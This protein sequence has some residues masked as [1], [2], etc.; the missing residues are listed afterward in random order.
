VADSAT[1][2]AGV[3]RE[4][5][6][7]VHDLS[8]AAAVLEWDLETQMPPQGI[9]GRSKLLSTI[10]GLRH[11]R[12]TSSA[13]ADAL[14]AAAEA[15]APDS[16]DAAQ[17]REV[18]RVVER[19]A[20]VPTA[21]AKRLAEASSRGHVAWKRAREEGSF[22]VFEDSLEEL[23]QLRKEEA[24][25]IGAGERLPFD[26]LLDE[27][28][29][30]AT[31]AQL[32]PL[33]DELRSSLG[34]I[35]RAV[36]DSGVVVDES[37]VT[38]TFRPDAQ[39]RF[40]KG[41]AEAMGFDFEAGRLDR[42]PHPF[43]SGFGSGDVRITWRWL[44]DDVRSALFGIMHE[45]G[46]GLYE[47]GLPAAWSRT[48]LGQPVSL[49]VHESQSRLWENLVGR[50]RPFWSWALPRYHEAFPDKA[51]ATVDQLWPALH[52]VKPS[53]IRVE[54]DEATYNLHIV[55][56]FEIE[57]RLFAGQVD[58][59]DLPALWDDL[60]E[61]CLGIRPRNVSEGV[62]QDIHWSMGAFGYFPTYTLGNLIA[63]QLMTAAR[64]E[65]G[66]VDG[67]LARGEFAPLLAWLRDAVHRHGSRYS[68][69]ELV[70]RATGRPLGTADFMDYIRETTA[71]VYGVGA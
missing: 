23:V 7:E 63:S 34:P 31:E 10:A 12:L 45:A 20:R 71:A 37:P 22:A 8:M 3:L 36:A 46:H 26:V 60:Y 17:V 27:F 21:L 70:E 16:D 67:Q 38:G 51:D 33:F 47:Q 4:R 58:V 14:E 18:R 55:V 30:D 59:K 2:A 54:A 5:W 62:L 44:D 24:D 50:S 39:L 68:A 64:A 15:A 9:E 43:C 6:A 19:A 56:R 49:G 13:L 48:P 52:T 69:A 65:L 29:P 40:S 35:V 1:D 61:E 25:A 42:A 11:E 28:E 53:F 41:V 57:R 32:A 66:D